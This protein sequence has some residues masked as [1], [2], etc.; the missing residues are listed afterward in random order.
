MLDQA[1]KAHL[2]G[3][4]IKSF[5]GIIYPKSTNKI[6]F[7]VKGRKCDLHTFQMNRLGQSWV[8]ND[9]VIGLEHW[10][11]AF[12]DDSTA[13]FVFAYWLHDLKAPTSSP[14]IFHFG[15]RAYFFIVAE[16][17][18][19]RHHMKPRSPRWNTVY[20]PTKPFKKLSQPFE[21]FI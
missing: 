11:D 20:V 7:D 17:S 19:Y 12:G 21:N 6:L 4:K 3:E 2:A 1:H 13:I 16:L 10:L 9:D 5:D 18:H 14:G 15:Q 8:T